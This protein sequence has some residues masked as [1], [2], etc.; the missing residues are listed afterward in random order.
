M[1]ARG[2]AGAGP[3]AAYGQAAE[4]GGQIADRGIQGE[5]VDGGD[6]ALAREADVKAQLGGPEVG[7]L[8]VGGEQVDQQG[9]QA[10]PR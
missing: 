9:G 2:R 4:S 10:R 7:L 8:L 5:P 1:S 3:E 6:D